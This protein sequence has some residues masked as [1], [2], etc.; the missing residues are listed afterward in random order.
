MD[1]ILRKDVEANCICV[2]KETKV[3]Q[4]VNLYRYRTKKI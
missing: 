2:L 1:G 3:M 4:N